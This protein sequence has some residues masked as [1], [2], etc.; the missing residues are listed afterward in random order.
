LIE[1]TNNDI[2]LNPWL[3]ERNSR[4]IRG[5]RVLTDRWKL[6]KETRRVAP[7]MLE[8]DITVPPDSIWFSGHF[9]GQP[10]LPGIALI[11]AVC[12]I[13]ENEARERGEAVAISSLKRVRFTGPVRPGETIHLS[14]TGE[15]GSLTGSLS[16]KVAVH[17]QVIC[18]GHVLVT[19]K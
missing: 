18:T 3:V 17:G 1:E 13:I 8:A 12:E 6:L 14:V 19:K 15:D 10:I 2:G 16:F 11:S 7:G 4:E 9:P 5:E